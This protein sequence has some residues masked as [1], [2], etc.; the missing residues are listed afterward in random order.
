MLTLTGP[1]DTTLA[2]STEATDVNINL[3]RTVQFATGALT[4]QR[5][6]R[7]QAPTYSFVGAS[8]ITNAA[9][10]DI[11]GP[12]VAGTNAT[13]TNPAALIVES[14]NVGI[15]TTTPCTSLQGGPTFDGL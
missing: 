9:T 11:S 12:P 4:T 5:A 7:I 1:A 14:G 3:A 13:I 2:A 10:V 15:G 6:M 8:T